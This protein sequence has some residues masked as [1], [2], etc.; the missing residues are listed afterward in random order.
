MTTFIAVCLALIVLELAVAIA[1]FS[2]A[3]LKVRDAA[4]A[5]EVAAYRVDSEVESFSA[6]MRSGWGSAFKGLLS[7]GMSFLRR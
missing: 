6:T 7:A 3:M 1:V 2:A 4:Q 5:L